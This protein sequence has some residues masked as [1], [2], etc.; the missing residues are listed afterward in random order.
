M[1]WFSLS[2]K[3]TLVL[4]SML[5]DNVTPAF[6]FSFCLP[7]ISL[8]FPIILLFNIFYWSWY[9]R[10]SIFPRLF[11]S[12]LNTSSHPHSPSLVY[13]HGSYIF[14]W[15]LHFPYYSY[16]P[17]VYF[18]P[19]IYA[20]YSLYLLPLFSPLHLPADNPP[21]DLHFCDSVPVVVVCLVCF[22]FRFV[23]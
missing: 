3:I 7:E 10:Y 17:P 5:S 18:I 6:F 2:L 14:L 21:C 9:Y 13:V 11:P 23:C 12:S 4:K 19:I 1:Y 15:L 22:C 8:S 16:P 20:S